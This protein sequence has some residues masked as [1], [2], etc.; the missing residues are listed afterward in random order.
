M[1]SQKCF[2]DFCPD[3]TDIAEDDNGHGTHVSGIIAGSGLSGPV[4]SAPDARIHAIKVLD[5][6]NSFSSTS[7]ITEALDYIINE[8]PEVDLVNM[9]LGTNQR[10]ESY[11]DCLLY[12]SDAADE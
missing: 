1:Q 10:F 5:N 11:C 6:T 7:I 4:G 2:A 12:T 9:S 3:G 8:L